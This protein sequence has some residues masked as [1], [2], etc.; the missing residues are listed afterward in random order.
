MCNPLPVTEQPVTIPTPLLDVL[1]QHARVAYDMTLGEMGEDCGVLDTKIGGIGFLSEDEDLPRCGN[2]SGPMTLVVQL[3][4]AQMPSDVQET[5]G[6]GDEGLIQLYVCKEED[7]CG[8]YE[9]FSEAEL[10][11]YVPAEDIENARD[12]DDVLSLYEDREDDKVFQESQVK[13]IVRRSRDFPK[14]AELRSVLKGL[15]EETEDTVHEY[16]DNEACRV[17]SPVTVGGWFNGKETVSYPKCPECGEPMTSTVVGIESDEDREML[18]GDYAT[19]HVSQC[20]HHRRVFAM[21]WD[22]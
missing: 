15:D 13:G 9:E 5:L 16:C 11:R 19:V 20:L 17:K 21:T 8:H 10:V 18:W 6:L 4:L 3:N 1:G 22:Y 12:R 2:C 7:D 14:A